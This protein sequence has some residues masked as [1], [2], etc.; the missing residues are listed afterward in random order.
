M[1]GHIL[2]LDQVSDDSVGGKAYGLSRLVAMGLAVPPAFVIRDAQSGSYPGD[3][4]QHYLALGGDNFNR[5]Q[6]REGREYDSCN[7]R[8][9]RMNAVHGHPLS[10]ETN[11]LTRALPMAMNTPL[12]E[13]PSTRNNNP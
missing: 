12:V 8:T 11:P 5:T 7:S 9:E 3:L 10:F 6:Q 13:K 4:D 2:S 1:S